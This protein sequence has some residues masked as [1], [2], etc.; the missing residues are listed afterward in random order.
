MDGD[1][2]TLKLATSS[3]EQKEKAQ[4]NPEE[5]PAEKRSSQ[6]AALK[7]KRGRKPKNSAD[8]ASAGSKK[9]SAEAS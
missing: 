5:Q 2:Q 6:P 8:R 9:P 7:A 4:L 1:A 3:N